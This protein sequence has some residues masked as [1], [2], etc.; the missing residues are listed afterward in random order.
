MSE[1]DIHRKFEV[2][3]LETKI[4]HY[5]DAEL[6][7]SQKIDITQAHHIPYGSKNCEC[8]NGEDILE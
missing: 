4:E 5:P 6:A 1:G 8:R 3:S 2:S 7:I